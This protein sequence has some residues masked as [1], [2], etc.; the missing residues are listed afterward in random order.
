[1]D[2][3]ICR[4][5]FVTGRVQGVAFRH[6]T[7]QKAQT[8]GLSGWV[9]N[10]ADGRVE[11]LACGE[12]SAVN[13]LCVWLHEGPSLAEVTKV[14]CQTVTYQDNLEGFEVTYSKK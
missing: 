7:R 14:Q 12:I 3:K 6:Y 8:C 10:L 1:M 5:C 13:N 4:H 9:R 11:V 2:N